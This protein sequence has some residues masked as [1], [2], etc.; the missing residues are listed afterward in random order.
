MLIAS[1][2]PSHVSSASACS[3]RVESTA[4]TALTISPATA[5]SSG[6]V[7]FHMHSLTRLHMT[8]LGWFLYSRTTRCIISAT[9]GAHAEDILIGKLASSLRYQPQNSG[10]S[11][12]PLAS[13]W[14]ITCGLIWS[15]WS[16]RQLKFA[17]SAL[18]WAAISWSG[19]PVPVSQLLRS[20]TWRCPLSMKSRPF[21]VNSLKPKRTQS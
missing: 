3:G 13:A 18:R 11:I 14:S 5:I 12:I 9:F 10:M 4:L 21:T 2:R 6:F 19:F 8:M 16:L 20:R 7:S 15:R 17:V 1:R